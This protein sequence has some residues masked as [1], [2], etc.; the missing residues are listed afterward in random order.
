MAG[1]F[2]VFVV[3]R[4]VS[5]GPC[6][7]WVLA[8]SGGGHRA[9]TA[10]SDLHGLARQRNSNFASR[11]LPFDTSAC[12]LQSL[13]EAAGDRTLHIGVAFS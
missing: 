10:F 8:S 6:R 2:G 11:S 9:T 12:I 3:W 4:Y 5:L 13:S 7:R 1:W